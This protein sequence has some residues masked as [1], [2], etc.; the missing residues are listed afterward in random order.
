[1]IQPALLG[2]CRILATSLAVS[3]LHAP[4]SWSPDGRWFAYTTVDSA[5]LASLRP[6]WLCDLQSI[7]PIVPGSPT[8]LPRDRASGAALV[9]YRI[10]ALERSTQSA[11]LIEES[12]SPLSSPAWGP[13]GRT[14]FY[15]RLVPSSPAADPDRFRGRCE[16]VLREALNRRRVLTA[17]PE[18]EIDGAQLNAFV[19][20]RAA[21]SPDGQYL[22]VF[23]PGPAAGGRDRC[24]RAGAGGHEDGSARASPRGRPMAC[25]WPC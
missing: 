6:G 14:L 1:M 17:F 24:L 2:L 5:N 8:S 19:E 22:A 7:A 23:W 12:D 11:V 16:L 10:W 9:H 18:V 20:S 4:V 21:W 25:G 15:C 13:D 3:C